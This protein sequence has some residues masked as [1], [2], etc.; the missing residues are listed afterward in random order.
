MVRPVSCLSATCKYDDINHEMHTNENK[1]QRSFCNV[2]YTGSRMTLYE[3][4]REI[5]FHADAKDSIALW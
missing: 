1:M 4:G 3:K 2:V 5:I